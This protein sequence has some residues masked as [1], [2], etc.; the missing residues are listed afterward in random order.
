MTDTLAFQLVL[1]PLDGNNPALAVF[2][3]VLFTVLGFYGDHFVVGFFHRTMPGQEVNCMNWFQA[4][5]YVAAWLS[6]TITLIGIILGNRSGGGT[7]VSWSKL[8]LYVSFLTC[9]A[10]VFTPQLELPARYFAGTVLM[11]ELGYFLVDR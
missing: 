10:A 8:M 2:V 7:P 4:H 5:A 9:L 3:P 6:P 1:V 11:I